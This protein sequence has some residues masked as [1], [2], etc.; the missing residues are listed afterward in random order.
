[1]GTILLE[2]IELLVTFDETRRVLHDAWVLIDGDQIDPLRHHSLV[3]QFARAR[4]AIEIDWIQQSP[5]LAIVRAGGRQLND[6]FD[7]LTG[8][9]AGTKLR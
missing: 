1:M 9:R 7:P 2:N 8:G 4:R 5:P 3:N 6:L